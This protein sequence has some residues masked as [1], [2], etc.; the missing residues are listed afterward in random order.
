MEANAYIDH[1][2]HHGLPGAHVR[3]VE[4]GVVQHLVD[5]AARVLQTHGPETDTESVTRINGTFKHFRRTLLNK[6]L[7]N[8]I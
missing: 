1:A 5:V 4:E 7:S 2:V 3:V 6:T 8:R